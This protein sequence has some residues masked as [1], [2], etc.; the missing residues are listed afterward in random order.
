[1]RTH[2]RCSQF[3]GTALLGGS[4]VAAGVVL[5]GPAQADATSF[6]ND[7]HKD[8]I[9]AVSGGDGA[10]LQAGL[11]VCQQLSWGAPPAQLEGLAL[12]RSD[13]NQGSGGL[14]PKQADDVVNYAARDLCPPT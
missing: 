5:A 7:M 12:Q 6:L 9:H 14:T 10:L 11:N 3:L 4:L 2:G 8:G 13:D 1:M